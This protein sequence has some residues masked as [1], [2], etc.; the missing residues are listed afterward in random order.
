[1]VLLI[2]LSEYA[3]A[4]FAQVNYKT[5]FFFI[6]EIEKKNKDTYKD[7]RKVGLVSLILNF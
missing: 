2:E 3:T 6:K 4:K 7:I 1:M 5:I